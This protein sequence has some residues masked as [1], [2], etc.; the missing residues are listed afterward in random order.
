[1]SGASARG[2]STEG[3]DFWSLRASSKAC[4]AFGTLPA[5]CNVCIKC[6]GCVGIFVGGLASV[7]GVSVHLSVHCASV[8]CAA[9]WPDYD[10]R[11]LA[12]SIDDCIDDRANSLSR[13]N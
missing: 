8:H 6:L 12:C 4:R 9:P 11:L 2:H 3:E 10:W 7:L 13:Y 5:L 1:M